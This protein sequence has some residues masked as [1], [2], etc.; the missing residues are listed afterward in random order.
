MKLYRSELLYVPF[1][2]ENTLLG[3][4]RE[5]IIDPQNGQ[6][7][8]YATE[9]NLSKYIPF[10]EAL[11]F[12]DRFFCNE[13][14]PITDSEDVIRTQAILKENKQIINKPVYTVA[15]D[16]VGY[17]S[18]FQIE[19]TIGQ[20]TQICTHRYK[21]GFLYLGR[22]QLISH[23]KIYAIEADKVI[24][25]NNYQTVKAKARKPKP[26]KR[27]EPVVMSPALNCKTTN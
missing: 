10:E 27:A 5:I 12:V 23:L 13:R 21:F 14:D 8:G 9:K 22:N 25:K 4:L 2:N 17:I 6:V 20:L 24:V 26:A 16:I 18:D 15:G 19:M 11:H 1:F 3:L 7:I